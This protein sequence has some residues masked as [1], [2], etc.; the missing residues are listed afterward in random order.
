MNRDRLIVTVEEARTILGSDASSM[1]DEEI[2]EVISSLDI[3]AKDALETAQ[4][5]LRMKKDANDL[6]NLIYDIYQDKK[7][8]EKRG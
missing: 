3:M 5:K 7:S 4:A 6:A 1:T 8:R 2:T